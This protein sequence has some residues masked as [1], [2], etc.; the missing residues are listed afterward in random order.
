MKCPKLQF[1]NGAEIREHRRKLGL[2]QSEF[3]T[4]V[5]VTQSGASRYE[6]GR[7]IPKPVIILLNIAFAT[8]KVSTAL[9]DYQRSVGNLPKT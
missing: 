8:P 5:G 4:R 3:W 1:H 2:N 7:D 9:V 6:K